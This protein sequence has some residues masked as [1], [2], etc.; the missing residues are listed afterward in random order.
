MQK[1][2]YVMLQIQNRRS[3]QTH[4]RRSGTTPKH[5]QRMEDDAG[6]SSSSLPPQ[7]M[8]DEAQQDLMQM[9]ASQGGATAGSPPRQNLEMQA[10]IMPPGDGQKQAAPQTVVSRI[11]RL[12]GIFSGRKS[13]PDVQTGKCSN[14][15]AL[16]P[17][18]SLSLL[19]RRDS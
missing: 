7:Q 18:Y 2:G 11:A 19:R 12:A 15:L 13:T 4:H 16:C 8:A 17:D 14:L 10:D 5:A 9:E 6:L 1:T 3:A